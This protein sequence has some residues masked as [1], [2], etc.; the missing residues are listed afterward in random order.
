ML[1]L[2]I[3][4]GSLNIDATTTALIGLSVLLLSQVLTWEDIK[5]EQGAWDTLTWFAA[6]VM[7]ANFLNE[8]GMVSWFS[9]M[10]KS[11]V[12]GFSW[13]VAF[14]ILIVVYYYTHYFFASATAHISAMYA[15]FLAVI[16][17]AGAPPLLAALS[18]AFFSNLSVRRRITAQERLRSFSEQAIYR[19]ANGGPSALSCQSSIL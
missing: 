6:L 11:S 1:A 3:F 18:L 14:M 19:K 4:G 5:K 2:W 16:V 12:S 7:L 10:M 13:I 17:A 8:L 15:A 9:N